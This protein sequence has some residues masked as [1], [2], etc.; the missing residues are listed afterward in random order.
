MNRL[1]IQ[2]E[3]NT[4]EW[5]AWRN[6]G[7]GATDAAAVVGASKFGTPLT[8]FATK[9][10]LVRATEQTAPIEWGHRIEPV[11]IDKI[12]EVHEDFKDCKRGLLYGDGYKHASLDAEAIWV[13]DGIEE[14]VVIEAKT[15]R[16]SDDWA[17]VP[18]GYY[19]QVQWQMGITGYKHAFFTVLVGGRDWFEVRV[20]FDPQFY[21]EMVMICD[22]FWYE[23][24]L[25]DVAPKPTGLHP[26]LDREAMSAIST[27]T[28][29]NSK[30]TELTEE[31]VEKY[32]YLK[33]RAESAELAFNAFKSE[34][35]YK[36]QNG[37]NLVRDGKKVAFYVTRTPTV[38][39][40][41]DKLKKMFPEAYEACLKTGVGTRYVSFKI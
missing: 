41:K 33:E 29:E 24:Y 15:A 36:M 7:L 18:P 23:Y 40:D 27:V 10:G 31:E 9:K 38:S 11:I 37:G 16:S 1:E 4:D 39:V 30:D 2:F 17:P 13:H 26:D 8:V 14:P 12:L 34:L 22:K 20:D 21:E 6:T 19:A 35:Q 5:L 25:N 28:E 32:R 3:Q